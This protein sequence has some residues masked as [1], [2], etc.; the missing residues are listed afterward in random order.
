AAAPAAPPRGLGHQPPPTLQLA[1]VDVDPDQ[2]AAA[3][4]RPDVVQRSAEPAA[5][6]EDRGAAGD[7]T[8]ADD[9]LGHGLGRGE[10]AVRAVVGPARV[11]EQ[12]PVEVAPVARR[13][14]P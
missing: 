14:V 11:V 5:D 6:V 9:P 8:G 4:P 1:E 2:P 3:V 7:P 13:P 12:T 10:V